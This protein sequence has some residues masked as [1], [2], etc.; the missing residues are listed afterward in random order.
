MIFLSKEPI[1]KIKNF[2]IYGERHSG[3]NFLESIIQKVFKINPTW[4]YGWKHFFGFSNP[5]KL[6]YASNT[7]FIGTARNPYDWIMAMHKI[8]HH[9]P[10]IN[11]KN[12]YSMMLNQWMSIHNDKTEIMEDRNYLNNNRY[13]NIFEMRQSKLDYLIS[14]LPNY[15][16]NYIIV[17]YENMLNNQNAIINMISR[18]FRLPVLEYPPDVIYKK[19]YIIDD[20]IKQII[21]ENLSWKLENMYGYYEQKVID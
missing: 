4:E 21:N 5:K 20:Q 6:C 17:T 15:V 14:V 8:P 2:T 19:P 16:S 1:P 18:Q 7:L 13:N 3:T 10:S 12:I 11:S 9:L